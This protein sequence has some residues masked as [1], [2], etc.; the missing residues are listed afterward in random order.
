MTLVACV[1]HAEKNAWS[2]AITPYAWL[3]GL[4]GSVAVGSVKVPLNESFSDILD[5]VEF[6]M[7]LGVEA[8]NDSWGVFGD[9]T[10]ADLEDEESATLG[11][12]N[13]NIRQWLV[14]CGGFYRVK[15]GDRVQLDLGAG[16][17]YMDTS[18]NIMR[19][20]ATSS[21]SSTWIDPILVARLRYQTTGKISFTLTGDIGGFGI[22]SELVWQ[23]TGSIGYD[24][25]ES[26]TLLLSYR[27]LD[28]EYVD[29]IT[30]DLATSGLGFGMSFRF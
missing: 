6:G 30:Y 24:I 23:V 11:T 21:G 18:I 27:R 5:K 9:F 3:A 17:R 12:V 15:K 13:T 25:S 2:Y 8:R 28:Y 19:P 14:S 7:M 16:V 1:A 4:N 10:F 26:M 29:D 20:L 22:E